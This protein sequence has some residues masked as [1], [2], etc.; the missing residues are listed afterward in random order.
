[1]L[2]AALLA[3]VVFGVGLA[4]SAMVDPR[5]VL[6]FLD[7]TGTWDPSL[8]L[9]L[10]GAVGVN[11][12]GYRLVLRRRAPLLETRFTLPTAKHIDAPLL[13]GAAVFGIGWGLV[14]YCPGPAIAA[15]AGG[16]PK[17]F[18]FLAAMVAGSMLAAAFTRPRA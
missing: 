4:L 12:V 15:L 17:V 6:G 1:M 18:G 16:S 7:V 8:A 3:G 5:K 11:F 9:V 13:L 2:L 10:A 14:G